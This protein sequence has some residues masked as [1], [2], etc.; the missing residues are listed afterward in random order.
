MTRAERFPKPEGMIGALPSDRFALLHMWI[1]VSN[2]P[3]F[4]LPLALLILPSLK[5]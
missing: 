2:Y 5:D 1:N 4:I 3:L